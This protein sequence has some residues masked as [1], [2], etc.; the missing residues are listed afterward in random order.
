MSLPLSAEVVGLSPASWYCHSSSREPCDRFPGPGYSF[1]L[2]RDSVQPP[3]VPVPVYLFCNRRHHRLTFRSNY[4][5][6][7]VPFVAEG[8]S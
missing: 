2:D 5:G 1:V 6:A 4:Q 8:H 3:N 7:G